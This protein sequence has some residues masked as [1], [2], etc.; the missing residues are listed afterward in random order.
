MGKHGYQ[1]IK[2]TETFDGSDLT[3]NG[4]AII[5][6]IIKRFQEQWFKVSA[7]RDL[8]E[9]ARALSLHVQRLT[10]RGYLE[11]KEENGERM[12]RA[13]TN[14]ING[15]ALVE[16]PKEKIEELKEEDD[17]MPEQQNQLPQLEQ[18]IPLPPKLIEDPAEEL[19]EFAKESLKAYDAAQNEKPK[20]NP[21]TH[22]AFKQIPREEVNEEKQKQE[23]KK[24]LE[25]ELIPLHNQIE[26]LSKSIVL[27][28]QNL[29]QLS[30]SLSVKKKSPQEMAAEYRGT[31]KQIVHTLDGIAM[32]GTEQNLVE[33]ISS[34]K[35]AKH[36][37]NSFQERELAWNVIPRMETALSWYMHLVV[38]MGRY[39]KYLEAV[40]GADSPNMDSEKELEIQEKED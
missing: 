32:S 1:E 24:A 21:K 10:K 4:F 27:M 30:Q 33:V 22:E 13:V 39:I 35:E 29:S 20:E 38:Q 17:E 7:I 31:V 5:K 37:M 18:P 28:N 16:L 34:Y 6:E 40:A 12:L 14:A 25:K 2:R 11:Y 15:L 19:T 23:I 8:Q 3:P 26:Y 9:D 36:N